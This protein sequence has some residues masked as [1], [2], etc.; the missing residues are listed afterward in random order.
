MSNQESTNSS[1]QTSY[2]IQLNLINQTQSSNGQLRHTASTNNSTIDSLNDLTAH[3]R[4]GQLTMAATAAAKNQQQTNQMFPLGLGK[5]TL[6][7]FVVV[8]LLY[9]IQS[10]TN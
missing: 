5:Q 9:S 7:F 2:R 3:N 1:E 4:D 8:I 6:P 10:S